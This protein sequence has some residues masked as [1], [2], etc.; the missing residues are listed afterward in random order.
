[1]RTRALIFSAPHPLRRQLP[2]TWLAGVLVGLA[3]AAVTAVR[4]AAHGELV[5]LPGLVVGALFLP[6]LA[7]ALGTW[8]GSNRLFEVVFAAFWYLGIWGR[9]TPFDL[10]GARPAALAAGVPLYYL[11]ASAVLVAVAIAGRHHQLR[12]PA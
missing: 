8:T 3:V 6:S 1:M 9:I 7:L 4:P 12:H 2:A 5:A 11:A 10:L